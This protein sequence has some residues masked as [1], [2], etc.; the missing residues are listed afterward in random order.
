MCL[1]GL[2]DHATGKHLFRHP[3]F[4]WPKDSNLII[5]TLFNHLCTR[6]A[7][8][9]PRTPHPD[10]LFIQA[11]NCY[12]ENKNSYVFAFLSL[13]TALDIFKDIFFSFLIVR[14]LTS[15]SPQSRPSSDQPVSTLLRLFSY[16]FVFCTEL[17]F[18]YLLSNFK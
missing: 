4:S 11:D 1:G 16:V 13:L 7:A 12:A 3:Q 15:S 8:Y 14:I 10:T 6:P 18:F 2:I 5:T 9:P 17:L